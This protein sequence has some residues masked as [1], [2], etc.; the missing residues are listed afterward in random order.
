MVNFIIGAVVISGAFWLISYT[1][2][3]QLSIR[4]WG[5][6]ITILGFFYAVFVLEVI[7]AF[8]AEGAGRAALVNGLILGLIAVI[9][10]V[11]LMR[12]VFNSR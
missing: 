7:A 2:K 12:F 6:M 1:K 3:Q 10:A 8:L 5:W 11:L 4:W 9:W